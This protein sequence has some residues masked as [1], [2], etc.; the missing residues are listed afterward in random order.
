MAVG[1]AVGEAAKRLGRVPVWPMTL[2]RRPWPCLPP[3][4]FGV[5]PVLI[6]QTSASAILMV[7]TRE[8]TGCARLEDAAVG[9]ALGLLG[10]Q[11]LLTPN[12]ARPLEQAFARVVTPFPG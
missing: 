9:T 8:R 10:S 7:A 4:A 6:I 1:V 12:P 5:Q 2:S 11:V 3:W